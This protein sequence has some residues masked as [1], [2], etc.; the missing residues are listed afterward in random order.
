MAFYVLNL[1]S[2]SVLPGPLFCFA[3]EIQEMCIVLQV[4]PV[5][6]CKIKNHSKKINYS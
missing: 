3:G 5:K 4:Q 1:H 6:L 2:E